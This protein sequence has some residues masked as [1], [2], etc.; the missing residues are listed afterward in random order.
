V[1]LDADIIT[2]D[3]LSRLSDHPGLHAVTRSG[4]ARCGNTLADQWRMR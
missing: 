4:G 3:D 1:S 2:S